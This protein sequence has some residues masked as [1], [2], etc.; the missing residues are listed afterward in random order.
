V[1]LIVDL[2]APLV[3]GAIAGYAL[4][5]ARRAERRSKEASA[6]TL[7]LAEAIVRG[8]FGSMSPER[9]GQVAAEIRA[10][11]RKAAEGQGR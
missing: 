5:V 6:L 4:F 11:A 10:A 8:S 3:S 9:W 7:G 2:A 1:A